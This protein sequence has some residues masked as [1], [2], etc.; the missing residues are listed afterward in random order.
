LS[1]KRLFEVSMIAIMVV[2]TVISSASAD[3][4]TNPT[5]AQLNREQAALS[6]K[7][8]AL[9]TEQAAFIAEAKHWMKV[10]ALIQ[11]VQG[12]QEDVK[13][14]KNLLS[15]PKA[16]TNTEQVRQK[17][18]TFNRLINQ[19]SK[20][21]PSWGAFMAELNSAD[22][23]VIQL[24]KQRAA[25]LRKNEALVAAWRQYYSHAGGQTPMFVRAVKVI[26]PMRYRYRESRPP[27]TGAQPGFERVG[28]F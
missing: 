1:I 24:K 5:L 3:S 27:E 15:H 20:G 26:P 25:L 22:A 8:D 7:K 14:Y 2:A 28:F 19:H 23:Q 13:H 6:I 4:S 17:I 11:K 9:I 12:Y 16:T 21:L 18:A 10:S